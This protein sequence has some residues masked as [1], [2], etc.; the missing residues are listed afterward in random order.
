MYFSCIFGEVNK[1]NIK[2]RSA[3]IPGDVICVTDFLG[4][5]AA[6]LKLQKAKTQNALE[7][8]LV[9]IH[10]RPRPHLEEAQ[11]LSQFKEVHAMMDVSDGIASD[12]KHIC[13]QSKVG[14]RIFSGEIP[15][16]PT[17]REIGAKRHWNIGEL[18]MAG[19]EDY[20]LLLTIPKESFVNL[21]NG[22]KTQFGRNLY[23]IGEITPGRKITGLSGKPFSHF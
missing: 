12:I 19:G 6:G 20:C 4:D 10:H 17:L 16:S 15:I 11:W 14:A 18:A 21:N 3:A 9:A 8:K 7:K 23:A 5:S 2:R 1:N 22:F 13:D